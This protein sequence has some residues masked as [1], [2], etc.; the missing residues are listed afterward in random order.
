[1]AWPTAGGDW[2]RE[3]VVEMDEKF[4]AAVMLAIARKLEGPPIGIVTAPGTENP[5][6]YFRTFLRS[7]GSSPAG[8]CADMAPSTPQDPD[9]AKQVVNA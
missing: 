3:H 9:L 5:V 1:M 2:S 7:Y 8:A 4:Q 6:I